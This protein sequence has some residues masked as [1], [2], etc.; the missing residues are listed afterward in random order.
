[1]IYA[2]FHIH[3][4][5]SLDSQITPKMLVQRLVSHPSVKV[6]AVT[7]HGTVEGIKAVQQLAAPYPDLL[8]VP[9][10]EITTQLGD[11]VLL[12]VTQLPP[13]PWTPQNV[14][15][16]AKQQGAVSIAAHPFREFGLGD[17]VSHVAVDA[18]EVLNGGSSDPANREARDLA[19]AL[20]LP[21]VGGSDAHRPDD[22][23]CVYN[24]VQADLNLPDV[25]SAVRRGLLVPCFSVRSIH[26]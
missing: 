2:D 14:V 15:A 24:E 5:F 20:K 6:A 21:G 1:M 18:V 12:G 7:D 13:K 11:I 9:G 3:T 19:K 8:I 23:F 4:T 26:F 10:V 22:L 16:F 17:Y 25:L